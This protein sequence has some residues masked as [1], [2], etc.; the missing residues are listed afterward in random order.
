MD[1]KFNFCTRT[2]ILQFVDIK[3]IIIYNRVIRTTPKVFHLTI[4]NKLQHFLFVF[5]LDFITLE[6]KI[7][8]LFFSLDKNVG[9]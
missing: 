1:N 7:S 5:C 3:S 8:S 4:G 6:S 9:A 2:Q